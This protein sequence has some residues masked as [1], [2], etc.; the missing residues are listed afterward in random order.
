MVRV[1][2]RDAFAVEPQNNGAL[3]TASF[4]IRRSGPMTED[5]VVAYSLGGTAE[6]GADYERLP[7]LITIPAG[8]RWATVVVS[9]I[10]DDAAEVFET[11]V[12][13]LAPPPPSPGGTT[14]GQYRIS[15]RHKALA[16]ISDKDFVQAPGGARCVSLAG[17]VAH[18][19]F[20]A[21]D[22][23]YRLEATRDFLNWETIFDS[24]AVDGALHFLDEEGSAHPY[25]F[26]RISPELPGE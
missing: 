3:N 25:R 21:E 10:H 20:K 26:Y 16:L 2:A 23:Q 4:R 22:G 9:P 5:L 19:C 17:G 15:A 7:G 11:V 18:L 12:L 24:V 6:N 13:K 1:T 8:Q 14:A